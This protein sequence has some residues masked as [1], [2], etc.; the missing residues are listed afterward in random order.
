MPNIPSS[1]LT[2]L[3]SAFA[4][5][6]ESV[7]RHYKDL[8]W[9]THKLLF[10]IADSGVLG[11]LH[12][13]NWSV[14][15]RFAF[16]TVS[17]YVGTDSPGFDSLS[18]RNVAIQFV[19][20]LGRHCLAFGWVG[21]VF[22][23][24]LFSVVVVLA[25]LGQIDP[26]EMLREIDPFTVMLD[27]FMLLAVWY[28]FAGYWR[29]IEFLQDRRYTRV[30][31]IA[32]LVLFLVVSIT[33]W[34]SWLIPLYEGRMPVRTML[35][36]DQWAVLEGILLATALPVFSVIFFMLV[37]L[38]AIPVAIF[39]SQINSLERY[40]DPLL[41][42]PV[43]T[44]VLSPV[45]PRPQDGTPWQLADLTRKELTSINDRAK[46]SHEASEKRLVVFALFFAAF[47]IFATTQMFTRA[48]NEID[49]AVQN[50]GIGLISGSVLQDIFI[51]R[52]FATLAE[53]TFTYVL[54]LLFVMLPIISVMLLISG[55][56]RNLA[57]Q[58]TIVQAC[59]VAEYAKGK[60]ESISINPKQQPRLRRK[61]FGLF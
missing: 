8:V 32:L 60:D 29:W 3:D 49:T 44:L 46:I 37:G 20:Q 26:I 40:H 47:A 18:L 33:V 38:I 4:D 54:V 19:R 9:H 25:W 52:N 42:K 58:A 17:P 27:G 13:E 10:P 16:R 53:I 12:R 6:A 1:P 2:E 41:E 23:F 24:Y 56:A 21:Y 48:I 51:E 57:I 50:F 59:I 55:L 30:A 11:R 43:R 28:W 39:R 36:L 7:M 35:S 14:L 5:R 31:R 15:R 22:M 61:L 34:R 45:V